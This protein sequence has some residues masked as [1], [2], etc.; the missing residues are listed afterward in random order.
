MEKYIIETLK[1]LNECD[2]NQILK[3]NNE[4][5]AKNGGTLENEGILPYDYIVVARLNQNIIGYAFLKKRFLS[6]SR[7][8]CFANCS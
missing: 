7:Y 2:K 1:K 8:V 5:L 6:C 4:N 3:I